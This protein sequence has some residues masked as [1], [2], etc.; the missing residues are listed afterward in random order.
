MAGSF[1]YSVV[2]LKELSVVLKRKGKQRMWKEK[3][4]KRKSKTREEIK[5][6][7]HREKKQK[8]ERKKI[9]LRTGVRRKM[10]RDK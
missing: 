7:D 1:L 9:N 5:R 4:T 8:S 10:T 3:R 6:K 2:V